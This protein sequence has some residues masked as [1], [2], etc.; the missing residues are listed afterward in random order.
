[1]ALS[2]LALAN[3]GL[4]IVVSSGL[5][6]LADMA[7][8][9]AGHLIGFGL[10]ASVALVVRRWIPILL[11]TGIGATVALHAWLGLS[12]CCAPPHA[13]QAS[14]PVKVATGAQDQWLTVL[15]FN[16]WDAQREYGPIARYLAATPVDIVFLSEF[17][18]EKHPLLRE[19]RPIYPYQV[20][21][22]R[23]CSL[24]LLSRLPLAES[25]V[26]TLRPHRLDFVWARIDT[27]L[28]VVGTHVQ[29]PSRAP[30]LH[31]RQMQ[32]LAEFVRRIDGSVVLAGDFNNAPW[33]S[34]FRR[35]RSA[36]GLVP[37]STLTSTWPAWPLPLPQVALDHILV[38]PDL[39]VLATGTG[40]ALGSD[41]LPIWAQLRL[42]PIAVDRAPPHP[43]RPFSRLA[44]ARP[45]LGGELLADLGGKHVGAGDLRR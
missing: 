12:R 44:A 18:D 28:T 26:G 10:A 38:S 34:T 5:T 8:P 9:L 39:S 7:A 13:V 33:S 4:V 30:R 41:H 17:E 2:I 23:E 1:L 45:H 14:A 35:L 22:R 20:S 29:R 36:T 27:S 43:S 6:V 21:C 32:A 31:V 24:A 3:L 11:A 42:P 19:L 15:A 16:T 25:G 40:P 37:T